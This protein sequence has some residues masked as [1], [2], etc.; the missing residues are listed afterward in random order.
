MADMDRVLALL[1]PQAL[2]AVTESVTAVEPVPKFAM[3]PFV[4]C[5]ELTTPKVEEKLHV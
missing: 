3:I 4:P 5:P 2:L 1:A